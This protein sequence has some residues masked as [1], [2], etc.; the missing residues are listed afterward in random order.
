[1]NKWTRYVVSVLFALALQGCGG[2]GGGGSLTPASDTTAPTVS[3]T[4]AIFSATG[5][6]ATARADHTATM[7]SNGKVLVAGGS[8]S[9]VVAELYDPATGTW[10][11]TGSMTTARTSHT[12]ILLPNGKVLVAGG[13]NVS[14]VPIIATAELYW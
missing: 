4:V 6:M 8:G 7:L 13:Q 12:A 9:V 3:S 5:S 14:S 11:A 10:A 1:M 2:G